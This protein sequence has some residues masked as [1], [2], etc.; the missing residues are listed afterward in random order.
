MHL[1]VMGLKWFEESCGWTLMRYAGPWPWALFGATTHSLGI[2][3]VSVCLAKKGEKKK[4]RR[5]TYT[6]CCLKNKK[7]RIREKAVDPMLGDWVVMLR[8]GKI[9]RLALSVQWSWRSGVLV[10]V[11]LERRSLY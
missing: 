11:E 5:D 6:T 1:V 4:K 7:K 9:A 10:R 8:L 2:C 3:Q